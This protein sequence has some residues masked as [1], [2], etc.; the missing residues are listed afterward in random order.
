MP[1]SEKTKKEAVKARGWLGKIF[2][3]KG[4]TALNQGT[5]GS[6]TKK[7]RKRRAKMD[8]EMKDL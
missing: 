2:P 4:K 7:V 6:T 8:E 5:L 1:V 3:R